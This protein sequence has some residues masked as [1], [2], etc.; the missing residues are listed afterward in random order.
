MMEFQSVR[1]AALQ[2]RAIPREYDKN[3]EHV[4]GLLRALAQEE[5]QVVVMP[6]LFLHGHSYE[7]DRNHQKEP[8]EGP[9]L[10]WMKRLSRELKMM[11]VGGIAEEIPGDERCY[12]TLLFVD[13]DELVGIYRKRHPASAELLFLK[14]GSEPAVFDTRLGRIAL[15]TCFDT[16]FPECV[17]PIFEKRADL[18]LVANAWLEMEK[19]PFLAGQ[20]FEHH[21]VLPRALSMQL[22]APVAMA[23]LVGP[24]QMIVP[25]LPA[26]GGGVFPFDTEFAGGSLICD[27]MGVVL[28]ERP[29]E[30][31]PGHVLADVSLLFAR[32]TREVTLDDAGLEEMRAFVFKR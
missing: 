29:K 10:G 1:V 15:I 22:R 19:L 2:C 6:E 3:R 5:P 8:I 26:F 16:S 27:H 31:G 7:P 32:G 9:T 23:N 21:R 17:V 18:L 14:P 28:D 30:K 24:L 20:H 25:G 4:E 12:S 11:L 13:G